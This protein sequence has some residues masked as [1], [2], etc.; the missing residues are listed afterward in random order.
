ME[1]I[2]VHMAQFISDAFHQFVITE[3]PKNLVDPEKI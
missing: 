3:P 1:H 2:S